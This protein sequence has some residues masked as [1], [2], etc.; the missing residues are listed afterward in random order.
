MVSECLICGRISDRRHYPSLKFRSKMVRDERDWF[1]GLSWFFAWGRLRSGELADPCWPPDDLPRP[2]RPE[3][4]R[5]AAPLG[6]RRACSLISCS[7][8][9]LERAPGLHSS[10][11]SP[12][13]SWL[14][15]LLAI[16]RGWVGARLCSFHFVDTFVARLRRRLFL[17]G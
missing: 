15:F 3:P 16:Y 6:G 1:F 13:M 7:S 2:G 17:V 12:R 9:P 14:I 5:A 8:F 10:R 4:R 11:S